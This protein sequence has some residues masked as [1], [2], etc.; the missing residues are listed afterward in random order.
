MPS[1]SGD[2]LVSVVMPVHNAL[3]HLDAAVRSILAQSHGNF[4][5]V[6]FDDGS[7]DGSTER[8]REWAAQ[9]RRIRLFEG[10]RNLG[11]V[12]SSNFVVEH[13]TAPLIAR[14][15]ADDI[16]HPDRL[17]QQVEVLRDNRAVGL[18]GTLFEVI[19]GRGRLLRGAEVWRLARKT[20]FVPFPHGSIMFRRDI[21]ERVGGYRKQCEFWEDQDLV[22]RMASEAQICVILTAL[23]QHRQWTSNTRVAS[24][25]ERVENAVDLMYRSIARLEQNRSY[26]DLLQ[27]RPMR[28][29]RVD[30]R[31]FIASGS[32]LLWAGG[33]PRLFRRLL[34][35]GRLE[36]DMR[37]FS[38]LVWTAWASISPTSLRAFLGVLLRARNLRAARI[39]S[40]RGVVNWSPA[41]DP[42][43]HAIRDGERPAA[44]PSAVTSEKGS[45]T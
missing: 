13:S 28:G 4:E 43:T 2:E 3:P 40:R 6:I 12:G 39:A 21:F 44:G 7:S 8:L 45:S 27:A 20:P 1:R 9:D 19:D 17:R 30:P 10:E 41:T 24:D 37:T 5:F 31:V 33:R 32:L 14:M 23:Y 18:V 34:S 25:R 38:A 16:S 29:A 42:K 11:P 35:R 22:L 15:D 26:D 36:F